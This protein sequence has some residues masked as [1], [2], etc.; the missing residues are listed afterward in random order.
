MRWPGLSKM[1]SRKDAIALWIGDQVSRV[2]V[3]RWHATYPVYDHHRARKCFEREM[4]STPDLAA[5]KSCTTRRASAWS[6]TRGGMGTGNA[7]TSPGRARAA[8]VERRSMSKNRDSRQKSPSAAPNHSIS[9]QLYYLISHSGRTYARGCQE[10]YISRD[11]RPL[12]RQLGAE[13]GGCSLLPPDQSNRT[14]HYH[15]ESE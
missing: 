10:L 2:D 5:K 12:N 15:R 1:C 3:R 9:I 11:G 8:T 14:G 13:M 7:K 6:Q 4:R